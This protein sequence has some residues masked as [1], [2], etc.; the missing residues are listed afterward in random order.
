MDKSFSKL[1]LRFKI[2][3]TEILIFRPKVVSDF[4]IKSFGLD[5]ILN[6]LNISFNSEKSKTIGFV[7]VFIG[8]M[9]SQLSLIK[10]KVSDST[11]LNLMIESIIVFMIIVVGIFI[12]KF[13]CVSKD[14][15]S[16]L[17]DKNEK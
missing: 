11:I 12:F 5:Y 6:S 16:L 3:F 15:I 9:M 7:A 14:T 13:I 8:F 4:L 2:A 1:Q 17:I 10:L